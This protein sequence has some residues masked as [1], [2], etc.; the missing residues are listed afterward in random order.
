VKGLA[1]HG[2]FE[3]DVFNEMGQTLLPRP[4]IPCSGIDNKG[5][6]THIT[7]QPRMNDPKTVGQNMGAEF[8]GH[9]GS[10][11]RADFPTSDTAVVN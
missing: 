10:K 8:R 1:L 7:R 11:I 3:Q 5:T 6:M 2:S 4:F 9:R